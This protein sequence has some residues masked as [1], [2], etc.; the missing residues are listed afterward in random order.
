MSSDDDGYGLGVQ[1][2]SGNS[3]PPQSAGGAELES[4]TLQNIKEEADRRDSVNGHVHTN[5]SEIANTDEKVKA[6]LF[7]DVPSLLLED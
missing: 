1:Q 5:A 4:P 6:V 7:S 2:G 3:I